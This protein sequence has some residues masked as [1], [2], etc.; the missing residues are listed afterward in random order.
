[1][2]LV[3]EKVTFFFLFRTFRRCG[4][5]IRSP[6]RILKFDFLARVL[7]VGMLSNYRVNLRVG[8]NSLPGSTVPLSRSTSL[9]A[10]KAE[11]LEALQTSRTSATLSSERGRSLFPMFFVEASVHLA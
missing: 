3:L 6:P 9:T 7:T 11:T 2:I 4:Y 8:E 5:F 10:L 1:M